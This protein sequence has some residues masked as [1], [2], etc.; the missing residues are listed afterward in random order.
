IKEGFN[1]DGKRIEVEEISHIEGASKKE[2]GLKVKNTGNSIIRTIF[3]HFNYQ[4]VR[5]DC[6]MI[7]PLTKKDVPRGH[8][9]HLTV[10]EI[11]QLMML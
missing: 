4:I 9:K 3:E 6:V 2:V 11:Q 1:L 10:A 8:W 5:L 7:G